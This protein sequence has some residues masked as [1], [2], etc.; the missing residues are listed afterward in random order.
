MAVQYS[1]IEFLDAYILTHLLN[2]RRWELGERYLYFINALRVESQVDMRL[3]ID[4][5]PF[6]A[7][8]ASPLLCG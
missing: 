4:V 3:Y 6:L 2:L 8:R 7:G 5:T 1:G